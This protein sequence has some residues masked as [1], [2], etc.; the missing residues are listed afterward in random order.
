MDITY[1]ITGE[2]LQNAI[3]DPNIRVDPNNSAPFWLFFP[4]M[5]EPDNPFHDKRVRQAVS[6]ALD[7]DFLAQA[8]T[9]GMAIVTGNFIPPEKP[10][11]VERDIP[12]FN[13]EKA[14]QLMADAGFPDGFELDAFTPFPPVFSLAQRIMDSLRDIGIKSTLNTT[15]RPVFLSMLRDH[16][17]GFPGVQIAFSISTGPPDVA[18]YFRQFTLCE[19]SSSVTCDDNID[20][21]MEKYNA[22]LD[23]EERSGITDELQSYIHDEFIFVPIYINAFAMGLGPRVAGEVTD[24]TPVHVFTFPYEDIQLNPE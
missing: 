21:L 16:R 19:Q 1:F 3:D 7:R 8:E 23:L 24:L 11:Y 14:K 5:E 17:E 12:E 9:A 15:Q 22:S 20:T 6:L 10:G 2:L 18:A 4:G 13:L